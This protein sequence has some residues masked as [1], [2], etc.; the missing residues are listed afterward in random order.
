MSRRIAAACLICALGLNI[1]LAHAGPSTAEIAQ[2]EL[3]VRQSAGDPNAGPFAKQSIGAQLDRQPTPASVKR[4]QKRAQAR[5]RSHLGTRQ[6]ARC[7]GQPCP[8]HTGTRCCQEHVQ[9]AV[10]G[11][12]ARQGKDLVAR[13]KQS[14]GKKNGSPKSTAVPPNYD[15]VGEENQID[16]AHR[17]TSKRIIV[18]AVLLG[19]LIIAAAGIGFY[20]LDGA[21]PAW[22]RAGCL[23]SYFCRQ[24]NL[25]RLSPGASQTVAYVATQACDGS[26]NRKNGVGR[27]LSASFDYYGVRSRFFRK[28]DKYFVETDG[29]DGKL[30]VFEVKYT[31]GIEPLQQYLVEFPDGR[32]QAL[33]LAW[34]SRP[35]EQGGQHWLHLYPNEDIKHDDILHWTKLNQNWNFMCSECHSTGV[36]KN[37]DAAN[38]R[39]NTTWAEISVGCEACHGQ[40]SHTLPGHAISSAGG[41]SENMRTGQRVSLCVL[42][43][44]ATSG[45]GRIRQTVIHSAMSHRRLCARR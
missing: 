40:G 3:A 33:S 26:C 17:W 10:N 12:R 1:E 30:A 11:C 16:E 35:K 14:S 29:P 8:V 15:R 23:S 5:V 36:R 45:G 22:K 19:A 24:R 18:I 43:N 38:D 41:L 4:A 28:G 2:F 7:A 42:T 9:S 27:F 31:F 32:L 39:Y 6:A 21:G 13:S 25:R 20:L 44:A 37:Y 34:D